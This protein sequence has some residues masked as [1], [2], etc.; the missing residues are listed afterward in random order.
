MIMIMI[1]MFLFYRGSCWAFSTVAA[2]EGI[3]QIKTKKLISLSEQQL[4]D[5]DKKGNDKGCS[6]GF[7]SGGFQY[8][9]SNGGITTESTY[10]YTGADGQCNTEKAHKRAAAIAGYQ[11][12][13]A[14][15]EQGLMKA[16][17][18]QPVSAAIDAGSTEF[19]LYKKGIFNSQS[20]GT[21]LN[22]GITVVGY[23]EEGKKKYW[24]VKNSWGINWG[25]S[26]YVRIARET[27]DKGGACGIA[28]MASYPHN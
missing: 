7:M 3:T 23:G 12:V 10:P 2:V 24:I 14:N 1:T 27:S 15:D 21:Q 20:C 13:P 19:Q 18:N 28:K 8:I 17:A 16:V 6:G 25:E 5:C 4:V 22:H 11:N 26:G 9:K